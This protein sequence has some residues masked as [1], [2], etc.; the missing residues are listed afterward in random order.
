MTRSLAKELGPRK[1][2]VNSINPGMVETEGV[3][4]AGLRRERL[5]QAG[6]GADAARPDRSAAGHR[7]GRRVP[8]VGRFGVDHR[9]DAVHLGRTPLIFVGR[10]HVHLSGSTV[11]GAA[12][13]R[14]GA[15]P[16]GLPAPSSHGSRHPE[17]TDVESD[18]PGARCGNAG[19]LASV[20]L[21]VRHRLNVRKSGAQ[22]SSS[23]KN[24]GLLYGALV[25]SG[26]YDRKR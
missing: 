4:A 3:H 19:S 5:P 17:P 21:L 14:L 26:C 24:A 23:W 1:I 15:K 6:R 10:S 13:K 12:P 22:T 16:P 20:C 9:R 18:Q 11:L 2:R 8:R 25:H 7:A